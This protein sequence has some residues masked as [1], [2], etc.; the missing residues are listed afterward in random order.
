MGTWCQHALFTAIQKKQTECSRHPLLSSQGWAEFSTML[1]TV[2]PLPLHDQNL[3]GPAEFS[4]VSHSKR[5]LRGA[6]CSCS[7]GSPG[8]SS[9][10]PGA[11]GK[12]HPPPSPAKGQC[13]CR[14]LIMPGWPQ[15]GPLILAPGAGKEIFLP[16]FYFAATGASSCSAP[17]GVLK[18]PKS[19]S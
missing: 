17:K 4:F 10:A 2:R 19:D 6:S 1:L 12:L 13:C 18:T 15:H 7:V 16:C 11:K 14:A 8:A 9:I 5:A 3:W